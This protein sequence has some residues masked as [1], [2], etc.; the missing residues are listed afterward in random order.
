[1]QEKSRWCWDRHGR[2]C[3]PRVLPVLWLV[4]RT[5]LDVSAPPNE[6]ITLIHRKLPIGQQ[7]P[8]CKREATM[9]VITNFPI[10]GYVPVS[11]TVL[12][13]GRNAGTTRW[14]V[15]FP[16]RRATF[17]KYPDESGH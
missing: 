5:L 6:D 1:M 12:G 14:L 9:L 10:R 16:Q 11:C 8:I 4:R 13:L 7:C 3:C 15:G 17:S 2:R